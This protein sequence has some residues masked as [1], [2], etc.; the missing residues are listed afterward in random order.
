ML[1]GVHGRTRAPNDNDGFLTSEAIKNKGV[2]LRAAMVEFMQ[3]Q[4]SCVAGSVE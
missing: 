1:V 4:A 3:E 2:K